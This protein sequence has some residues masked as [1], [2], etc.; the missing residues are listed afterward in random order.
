[1]RIFGLANLLK[2]LSMQI[3][4]SKQKMGKELR[5]LMIY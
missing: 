4:K 2:V 5:I 3:V 1:M